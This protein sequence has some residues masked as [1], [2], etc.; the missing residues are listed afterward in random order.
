M[1]GAAILRGDTVEHLGG[2]EGTG[3]VAGPALAVEQPLEQDGEDLVR[4]DDVA[5]LIDRADAVGVSVGDEAC[6]AFFGDD[7]EPAWR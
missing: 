7:C 4:V 2:V 3:D 1:Q 5:M 6:I